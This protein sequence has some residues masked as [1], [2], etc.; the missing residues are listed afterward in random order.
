MSNVKKETKN[1]NNNK[2]ETNKKIA[3]KK[4]I[5]E[6][7]N[8]SNNDGSEEEISSGIETYGSN[9]NYIEMP[10]YFGSVYSSKLTDEPTT[11]K[12]DKDKSTSHSK[13]KKK[14]TERDKSK[15]PTDEEPKSTEIPSIQMSLDEYRE[16]LLS[17]MEFIQKT[18]IYV[19]TE[20]Y[21]EISGNYYPTNLLFLIAS[22]F[23]D[24]AKV[25]LY[26][27]KGTAK[28]ELAKSLAYIFSGWDR[29][30]EYH[31]PY[32]IVRGNPDLT[33]ED[34]IGNMDLVKFEHQAKIS[35]VWNRFVKKRWK[36]FDELNRVPPQRLSELLPLLAEG[37]LDMFEST[38]W[39]NDFVF[40]ATFNPQDAGSYKLFDP[41]LDRF[42]I[43]L[44]FSKPNFTE[45]YQILNKDNE[46]KDRKNGLTSSTLFETIVAG[47]QLDYHE[48]EHIKKN[49]SEIKIDQK[50]KEFLSVLL[51]LTKS[52]IRAPEYDKDLA[53]KRLC[54]DLCEGCHYAK[55][56]VSRANLCQVT[57]NS[58]S[59]RIE[60]A[61]TSY[62]KAIAFLTNKKRVTLELMYKILPPFLIH[63][64]E[65][66]EA[67][68]ENNLEI[69]YNKKK[70][71]E[72]VINIAKRDYERNRRL[73][74]ELLIMDNYDKHKLQM[75]KEKVEGL[76]SPIK[77]K[78]IE[79]IKILE[80][81]NGFL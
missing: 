25:L 33:R 9:N 73:Y 18:K 67:L 75:L 56:D 58:I 10:W 71:V 4:N 3:N 17:L 69:L 39:C 66:N 54:D 12:D 36:I 28:T 48:I 29:E 57:T 20:E 43:S 41:L 32:A 76:D 47:F 6:T 50:V 40:F 80:R 65:I 45:S 70:F 23:I 55:T 27:G 49:I 77:Y 44:Y 52:C 46:I 15:D 34:F 74:S 22:A 59:A 1:N 53:D 13:E 62:S 51:S 35:P 60:T 81:R 72:I 5:V 30:N 78:M 26:G 19:P 21:L 24:K 31:L 8:L 2:N 42:D 63:R 7:A 64:V 14:E 11:K 61:L 68:F 37:Q 16:M 38:Y 79:N